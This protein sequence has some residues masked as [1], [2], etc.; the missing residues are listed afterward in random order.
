MA[1]DLARME[2]AL[3]AAD[4]AGDTEAARTIAR[5]IIEQR[6]AAQAPASQRTAQDAPEY[7]QESVGAWAKDY[8]S[9]ELSPA[10]LG[11]AL[12]RPVVQA[13]TAIPGIFADA[14]MAGWNLA[15]GQN[16]ELP[17]QATNRA[18][19]QYT[20]AP[21]GVVGKGAELV[22]TTLLG[23]R[24]P[25]PTIGKQA[26]KGFQPPGPELTVTQETFREARKAG[27][28]VPPATVKPTAGRVA[29]ESVGGK[30]AVQQL[31][32]RRNQTV[33]NRLIAKGLGLSED[34][35][36]TPRVL[37]GLRSKAGRVYDAVARSGDI[38]ADTQYLD[39]L[40]AIS[41]QSDEIA[42]AFPDANVGK[43]EEIGQLVNS[44]LRDRFDA[45]PA[46]AY[47]KELRKSASANLSGV[48][49]ADPAK[50]S[51]GRAQRDAAAALEDQV[52]RHLRAQGKG[53]LA[54]AFD[55]ARVTIAK[56]YSAEKALN[57]GTGNIAA[58]ALAAELKRGKPLSGEF[59]TVAKFAAAFP[60]A[61]DE[62]LTSPGVSAL[63]AALTAGG[64]GV[65]AATGGVG[66]APAAFA[67][68]VARIAARNALLSDTVQGRLIPQAAG[69]ALNPAYFA[70]GATA[71]AELRR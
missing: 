31:A 23:S 63:D 69:N 38:A 22:S 35:Q 53:A 19:D 50:V 55:K 15:T 68:P 56:T 52:L 21:E 34:A 66:A 42:A 33:T 67:W 40:A 8:L 36:I 1:T 48:N 51:L 61:A 13:A 62:V 60:K 29:A 57:P 11:S 37:D 71:A 70:G 65:L 9:R 2:R 41:R 27:Y 18:L 20:R 24:I 3:R 4:A 45:K 30:A 7:P 47:L 64:G 5:A 6:N 54:N 14:T 25:M 16:N 32:S 49:A 58:R 12:V 28:V 44:L 43:S 10:N 59:A 26:P 17:S 39:D 46:L